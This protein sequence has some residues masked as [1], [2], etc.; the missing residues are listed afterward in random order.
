MLVK[1]LGIVLVD[2]GVTKIGALE[3]C[4]F[5]WNGSGQQL[6]GSMQITQIAV[7]SHHVS[8]LSSRGYMIP[9]PPFFR[10]QKKTDTDKESKCSSRAKFKSATCQMTSSKKG[11][12]YEYPPGN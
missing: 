6:V 5:F 2:G 10:N 7:D 12:F 3:N 11:K 4:F 1:I 9:N 8:K